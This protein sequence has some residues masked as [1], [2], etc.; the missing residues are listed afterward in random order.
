MTE[1][2]NL[3]EMAIEMNDSRAR[4]QEINIELQTAGNTIIEILSKDFAIKGIPA[5]VVSYSCI[6]NN[7]VVVP[8]S[9]E[10]GVDELQLTFEE[11]VQQVQ[12][13]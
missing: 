2:E 7:I 3:L 6:D 1:I 4:L 13:R 5:K 8:L 11:F 9:M 10:D 12:F